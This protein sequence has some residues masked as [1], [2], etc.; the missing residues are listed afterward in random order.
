MTTAAAIQ[1]HHG[2]PRVLA[3]LTAG[4]EAMSLA[5]HH[6][7]HGPLPAIASSELIE[8]VQASGLRGRGGA[9]FP[10]ARKLL[11]VAAA[12]AGLGCGGQRVRDRAGQPQG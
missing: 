7:T 6:E 11:A 2:L 12:Q 9:D 10:T 4:A 8:T 1:A 3:G 5:E